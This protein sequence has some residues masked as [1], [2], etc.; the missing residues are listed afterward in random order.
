MWAPSGDILYGQNILADK[1]ILQPKD[2]LSLLMRFPRQHFL[3]FFIKIRFDRL[4]FVKNL[5][6]A[7][8]FIKCLFMR[9]PTIVF[10]YFVLTKFQKCIYASFE[11]LHR[12]YIFPF[13]QI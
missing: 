2:F 6:F 5:V 7:I 9:D 1:Y 11:F 8:C 10:Q 3:Y 4:I 12:K 13:N